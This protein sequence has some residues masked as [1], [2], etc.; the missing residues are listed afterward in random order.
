[1][2]HFAFRSVPSSFAPFVQKLRLVI[3]LSTLLYALNS[4]LFQT[5]YSTLCP[6]LFLL[7]APLSSHSFWQVIT[8]S[9]ILPY[10]GVSFSMLFDL[11]FISFFVTPPFA[12]VHSFLSSTNFCRFL[13]GIICVGIIAFY[14]LAHFFPFQAISTSLLSGIIFATIVFWS[15][16]HH[17]GQSSLFLVFPISRFWIVAG[18]A[19]A[20]FASPILDHDWIKVAQ[21]A[22]MGLAAYL[23]GISICRLRS[24][25]DVLKHLEEWLD[26]TYRQL[27]RLGQWYIMRPIR[28]CKSFFTS[29]K[30]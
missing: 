6:H 2:S 25:V 18:T 14:G 23:Y 24:H 13:L 10:P 19:A 3:G 27:T 26:Q 9:L 8:A 15:L 20:T 5:G 17:K 12:F 29:S 21:I 11:G 28:L 22:C 7:Q 16:L 30:H 4:D 1:M